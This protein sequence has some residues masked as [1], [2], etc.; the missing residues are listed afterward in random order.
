MQS[1]PIQIKDTRAVE[2]N[3]LDVVKLT[4]RAIRQATCKH[5]AITARA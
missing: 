1:K 5:V 3:Y 2:H 4:D